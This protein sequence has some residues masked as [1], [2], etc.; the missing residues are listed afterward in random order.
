MF[1]IRPST[2]ADLPTLMDLY[3]RVFPDEDLRPVV[4]DLLTGSDPV[5][6]LVACDDNALLAHVIFSPC[7]T[8]GPARGALLGPLAVAPDR[9]RQ[10]LGRAIVQDG[11]RRLADQDMGHVLVLGDPAYYSR[12]GFATETQVTPPY[13]LPDGWAPAWQSQILPGL[14][15]LPAGGLTLPKAWMNPVY[16]QA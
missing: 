11:L 3:P 7:H 13:A 15:P 8:A 12:L 14:A 5:L 1:A 4:T 16:W 9:Q 2:P 6:S 10:G